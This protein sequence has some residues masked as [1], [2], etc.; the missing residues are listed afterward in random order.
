MLFLIDL[1]E[2][3]IWSSHYLIAQHIGRVSL[4]RDDDK[5]PFGKCCLPPEGDAWQLLRREL[6][7]STNIDDRVVESWGVGKYIADINIPQTSEDSIVV[8][9]VGAWLIQHLSQHGVELRAA[10]K[11]LMFVVPQAFQM[12]MRI[13]V[14]KQ[15]DRMVYCTILLHAERV[16]E[17]A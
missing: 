6:A 17:N 11:A 14:L 3:V 15:R 13:C 8:F 10:W 2:W 5:C 12:A 1:L 7:T 16:T 4:L 9:I